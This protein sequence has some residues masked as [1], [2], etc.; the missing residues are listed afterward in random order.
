MKTLS[1]A[2]A[3]LPS[4]WAKDVRLQI[5]DRGMI[6]HCQAEGDTR[7]AE[8]I[9]LPCIPGMP[10]LHS[11]AHQ[12][13][14]AGLTEYARSGEENFWSWR[15]AMYGTALAVT[16]E[17]MQAI[18]AQLYVELL[19]AGYT[20]VAEF[21]YLHHDQN[22]SPYAQ[23]SELSARTLAAA[24]ETGIGST[25]LPVLYRDGGFGAQPS[26][27]G[28]RRFI[29]DLDGFLCIVEELQSAT[30]DD[31]RAAVGVAPHSLRAVDKDLLQ[32][33]VSHCQSGTMDG[34]IH[35]HIA[36]QVKEI[37]DCIAH[38]GTTPVDWLLNALPVDERW[39][40][41]HATH[42]TEAETHALA[43]SGAVA[44]LCPSTEGN[45]GDGF[46]PFEH[47][48]APMGRWGIGSDSH[49]SRSVN[50]ELRWLEYGQRMRLRQRNVFANE[51][52]AH[53]GRAMLEAA[54][55]GGAQACAAPIGRIAQGYQ[56]DFITL[57]NQ[58]PSLYAQTQ[59]SLLDAWIFASPQAA[60]DQVFVAGHACVSGGK[61]QHREA[62]FERFKH[63]LNQL[64]KHA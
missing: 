11:H 44:G 39:C 49:I 54:W 64:R 8:R 47:Y 52:H 40:L 1:L 20:W 31:P 45:L 28:Q 12:R 14:I 16:P 38:Y 21:Q 61:H 18:A 7:N 58:H 10:N 63:T 2:H 34:P 48:R 5:D 35:I 24:R 6:T 51:H 30:R 29:N 57:N 56:A 26:N 22:G 15:E 62:I 4:G 59:D 60:I 23:R 9:S 37:E 43:K 19:E 27:P 55:R 53:T 17:Q 3:L 50:E 41:I 25:L 13:A 42:M 32:A 46:F 33:L 36:E